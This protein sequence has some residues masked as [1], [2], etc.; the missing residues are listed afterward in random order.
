ML[1]KSKI[2][3]D[4]VFKKIDTRACAAWIVDF[5]KTSHMILT[6]PSASIKDVVKMVKV[7]YP[8]KK[9]FVVRHPNAGDLVVKRLVSA[10]YPDGRGVNQDLEVVL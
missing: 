8:R 4:S 10:Y 1:I 9:K 3:Y 7:F 2:K 5:K 6:D